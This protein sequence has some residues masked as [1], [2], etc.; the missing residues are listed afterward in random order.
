MANISIPNAIALTAT[1]PITTPSAVNG[2]GTELIEPGLAVTEVALLWSGY[3]FPD[4]SG[5]GGG[6]V[7]PTSGQVYPRGL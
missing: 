4:Y 6:S 1:V 3:N 5:G 7:R 2:A